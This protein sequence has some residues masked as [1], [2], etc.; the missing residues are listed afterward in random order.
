MI[1]TR[2]VC[3]MGMVGVTRS[4]EYYELSSGKLMEQEVH[5]G[6]LYY[7]AIGSKRRYSWKKCND[8]K[9]LKEI[10]ILQLPF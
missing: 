4:G 1:V 7:R 8:T 10:E 9:G 3:Y 6:A 2:W 5:C